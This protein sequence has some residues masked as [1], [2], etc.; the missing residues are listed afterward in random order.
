MPVE[1]SGDVGVEH[2]YPAG[3][4][5]PEGQFREPGYAE[6]AYH[7]HIQRY[8]Q[9]GGHLGGHRDAAPDQTEY[10]DVGPVPIAVER[11]GQHTPRVRPVAV[12]RHPSS[13]GPAGRDSAGIHKAYAAG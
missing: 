13:V 10:D 5:R 7:Q 11:D 6:L 3:A 4:Q 8:P 1:P 2:L 12:P 9:R